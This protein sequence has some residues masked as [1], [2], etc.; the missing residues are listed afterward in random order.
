MRIVGGRHRGRPLAAPA[1]QTIRP[2]G[3]RVRE[4]LFNILIQGAIGE[5]GPSDRVTGAV[6]L[7]AFIGTGALALEALSRGA[8]RAYGIDTAKSSLDLARRN[9]D[10]LG[11]S[12]RLTLIRADAR[13]PPKA[14]ERTSLLFLD[15]P[16][17]KGLAGPALTGLARAGWIAPGALAVVES[18]SGEAITP[19]DGWEEADQRRYG[20]TRVTFLLAATG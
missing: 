10:A 6:V 13:R 11:E 15:P 20:E 4:A 5:R 8:A 14:Q 3:D 19:P 7:D 17:G 9:A 1:S 12:E 16:Y 18:P 2:T